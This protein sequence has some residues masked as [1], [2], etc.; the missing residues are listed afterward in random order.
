MGVAARG[1]ERGEHRRGLGPARD[2]EAFAEHEILEPALFAHHAMLCGVE[3]CHVGFLRMWT[4]GGIPVAQPSSCDNWYACCENPGP[5][6]LCM[7][8]FS[9][10]CVWA[11]RCTAMDILGVCV[12]KAPKQ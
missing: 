2:H 11:L 10:F 4:A 6:L 12:F 1:L 7:G 8:L 5:I 3:V 9:R